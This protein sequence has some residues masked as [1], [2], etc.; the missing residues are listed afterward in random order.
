MGVVPRMIY[1]RALSAL[2]VFDNLDFGS[3]DEGRA[4]EGAPGETLRRASSPRPSPLARYG[5]RVHISVGHHDVWRA[6]SE[7]ACSG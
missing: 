3:V 7:A 5:S 4:G 6:I 2:R 1:K